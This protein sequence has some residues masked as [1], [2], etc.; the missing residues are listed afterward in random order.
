[1][2]SAIE[3]LTVQALAYDALGD[4]P[5]AMRALHRDLAL[6]EP[7][8][9]IRVF[10]DEGLPMRLLLAESSGQLAARG[11]TT[12]VAEAARLLAYVETLLA[13]FPE[14]MNDE[15]RTMKKAPPIHRSSLIVH[16]FV[17]PLSERELEVLRL[18]AQGH[19][20]QQIAEVLI[21]SVGTVKKH[22]NNIFGKLG[23]ESRTQAVARARA[24]SLL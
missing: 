14:T 13:A 22:L 20:N 21:V 9:Y 24:L 8:G 16:P 1:M 19:S 15:R 18:I 3:I 12:A 11:R 2:H 10:V 23:V 7:E 17:E 6:A 4:R 5:C